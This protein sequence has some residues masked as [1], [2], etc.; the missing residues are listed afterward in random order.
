M[1]SSV[2]LHRLKHTVLVELTGHVHIAVWDVTV[3]Q[4]QHHALEMERAALLLP[5]SQATCK[6]LFQ[7]YLA[8]GDHNK[9]PSSTLVGYYTVLMIKDL[10]SIQIADTRSRI[11]KFR[12]DR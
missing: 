10:L 2:H 7:N 12:H 8:F 1:E 5:L 6:L 4:L 9:N 3:C 11:I